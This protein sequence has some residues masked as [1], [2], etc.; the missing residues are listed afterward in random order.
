[1]ESE[2]DGFLIDSIFLHLWQTKVGETFKSAIMICYVPRVKSG[3]EVTGS[4]NK[5]AYLQAFRFTG[6]KK[7][8]ISL[9]CDA[10]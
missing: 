6:H 2:I 8:V 3:L 1:M 10:N 9:I 4:T 7:G 5:K